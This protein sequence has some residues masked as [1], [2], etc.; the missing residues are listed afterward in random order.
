MAISEYFVGSA[1][2]WTA[3]TFTSE[4]FPKD[5]GPSAFWLSPERQAILLLYSAV[6]LQSG[7]PEIVNKSQVNL[8]DVMLGA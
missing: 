2:L 6:S 8:A 4:E 5:P 3:F 7:A 1:T